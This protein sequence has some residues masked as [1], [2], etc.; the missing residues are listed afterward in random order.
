M[1][2]SQL[3]QYRREYFARLDEVRDEVAEAAEKQWAHRAHNHWPP[4]AL[5]SVA[6]S[7]RMWNAGRA[8]QSSAS[9]GW[10][11]AMFA[12]DDDRQA[13]DP[14]GVQDRARHRSRSAQVPARTA[15]HRNTARAVWLER[16]PGIALV[17]DPDDVR[18]VARS[19]ICQLAAFHSPADLH[20]T[21]ASAAPSRWD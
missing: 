9:C 6:G 12:G 17:G 13:A 3:E 14:G 16:Q 1:P 7:S 18:G 19:M 2:W 21:V 5:V 20:I 10:A 4:A 11:P 8:T 15:P